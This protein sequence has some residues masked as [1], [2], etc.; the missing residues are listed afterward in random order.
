MM[1]HLHENPD[2]R[3]AS[4]KLHC[5]QVTARKMRVQKSSFIHIKIKWLHQNYCPPSKD[6]VHMRRALI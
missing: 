5:F 6:R 1:Q 3:K 4:A 2:V